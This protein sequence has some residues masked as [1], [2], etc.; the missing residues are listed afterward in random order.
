METRR[1]LPN[2]SHTASPCHGGR[3]NN[4][5]V[6]E[7]SKVG[8]IDSIGPSRTGVAG[9]SANRPY[10]RTHMDYDLMEAGNAGEWAAVFVEFL[11]VAFA[12]GGAYDECVIVRA[13]RRPVVTPEHPG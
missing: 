8:A 6:L 12:I 10:L 2:S 7:M 4:R 5:V 13:V 3:P 11:D 9:G 1:H